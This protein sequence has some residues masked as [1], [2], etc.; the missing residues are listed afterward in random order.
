VIQD[1]APTT[2]VEARPGG[3]AARA[4]R[5]NPPTWLRILLLAAAGVALLIGVFIVWADTLPMP[6]PHPS[7]QATLVY[8]TGGQFIGRFSEQ[9]RVDVPLNAVP[10]VVI[11]AVVSTEDRHFWS[12]GAVN[13]SSTVRAVISDISGSGG[14]QGGSTI[15]QQYVK[16]AY[17][18]PK[19]TITRKLEEAVIAYRV[20]QS[21]PK[22]QILDEYLN[23]IYWGR[24]AYG[25]EAASEA[26]FGKNVGQVDLPEAALL[27]GII[28]DPGGADPAYGP[29]LARR[30]QTASLTAM[31]RDHKITKAQ[32]QA[33]L[34]KPFSRYV[35]PPPSANSAIGGGAGDD[36]F[37]AAVRAQLYREFGR[38]R[39]DG[40]GLRVY[41][42]LDPT[43]QA[44]AYN[45]VYGTAP[46]ALDPDKGTPSG[47]AVTLDDQGHVLAMVGG[48]NYGRAS[49]NL[50]LG[51]AGGGTGRQAGSTFKALMLAAAIQGGY[52]V[53]SVIP[54]PPRIVI[55]DGNGPGSPWNVTNY[56]GEAPAGQ[57]TLAEATAKSV[58]TVYAQVIQKLGA[59]K[60]DAIAEAM[61]IPK[62]VLP[63]PYLSQVLGT[64]DVSPLQMA[65]AYATFAAGGVYHTPILVSKVTT[66]DKKALPLPVA[67]SSHRVLTPAQAA[68]EDYVLQQVVQY[69]TGA[70]AGGIG[71]PVA[72]KTGTTENSGDAWFIGYTPQITTALWMGYADSARS[73]DGFRGLT[74]VTG[75]SI[76]AQLWH[77][78]MASAVQAQPQYGGTFPAPGNL[79]GKNIMSAGSPTGSPTTPT[80]ATSASTQTL[81]P[82]T[83]APPKATVPPT[84]PTPTT[85]PKGP[86]TSKHPPPTTTPPPA[87]PSTSP[88]TT[89]LPPTT[90]APPSG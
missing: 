79:A 41:T 14:L 8:G 51:A 81:P 64:A 24:G 88:P 78:Y 36:Y 29:S 62:S 38:E 6:K 46:G 55:P 57:M 90:N 1:E 71:T 16:Q 25:V 34:A 82:T 15:T 65:G 19:R 86:P 37:L 27:A 40:G 70:A 52:S 83:P 60:L 85:K 35:I 26:F 17:L 69:G 53:Q 2:A 73:M 12:E 61:G 72:G 10:A 22:K 9:N 28:K 13:P 30:F 48:Q 76:P 68:V 45:S 89:P 44:Q 7:P 11:N 33:A 18:T 87:P 63:H 67:P 75:G 84:G 21:Q 5:R 23:T 4:P 58:N 31:V 80:P 74:S 42:T 54:S 3:A 56:E 66:A 20:A 39:V 47:A 77:T 49:V 59:A 50:A 32:M 43:L